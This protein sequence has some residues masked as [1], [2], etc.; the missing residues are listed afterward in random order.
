MLVRKHHDDFLGFTA[1]RLV[2]GDGVR[3]VEMRE[4]H[5]RVL[6]QLAAT[7]KALGEH[8]P[9]LLGDG[10]DINNGSLVTVVHVLVVV[11][12]QLEHAIAHPE[13]E[14]AARDLQLAQ[15]WRV[16][17]GLDPR[18]QV[19]H[20]DGSLPHWTNDL[21]VSEVGVFVVQK[22]AHEPLDRLDDVL[23]RAHDRCTHAGDGAVHAVVVDGNHFDRRICPTTNGQSRRDDGRGHLLSEDLPQVDDGHDAGR[24]HGVQ[25]A[26]RSDRRE[27]INVSDENQLR[28]GLERLHEGGGQRQTQHRR[29]VHEDGVRLEL[30]GQSVLEPVHL[31]HIDLLLVYRLEVLVLIG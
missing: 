22:P 12:V 23:R 25:D 4:L 3:E 8:D 16:D 6:D 31:A 10:I 21:D 15:L 19:A 11:I 28:L 18:I 7:A 24:D 5:A 29:L 30:V 17:D 26:P 27:L 14:V 1:L 9:N 20:A 2:D 13:D